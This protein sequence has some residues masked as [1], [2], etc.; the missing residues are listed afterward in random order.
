MN[1]EITLSDGQTLALL[2]PGKAQPTRVYRLK[3]DLELPLHQYGTRPYPIPELA[4]YAA[5]TEFSSVL[6]I[7]PHAHC[8]H[9]EVVDRDQIRQ[10][11]EEN[12]KR[13]VAIKFG[14]NQCGADSDYSNVLL[15][16]AGFGYL[17]S[18]NEQV[19]EDWTGCIRDQSNREH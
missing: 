17:P 4:K 18:L 2:R 9:A 6:S 19:I 12:A 8:A 5:A 11:C 1:R 16:M 10:L 14:C 13:R 15:L 3:A 7:C